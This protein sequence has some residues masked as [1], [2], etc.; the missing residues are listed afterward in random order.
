MIVPPVACIIQGLQ[1]VD[2]DKASVE[3]REAMKFLLNTAVPAVDPNVLRSRMWSKSGTHVGFFGKTNWSHEIATA[4]I[5]MSKFSDLDN[6]LYNAGL[7]DEEGNRIQ[8]SEGVPQKPKKKKRK[9]MQTKMGEKELQADYY[10]LCKFL[11]RLAK[12]DG[13]ELRMKRWDELC[14]GDRSGCPA[15][16]IDQRTNTVPSVFQQ[17][18]VPDD[19]GCNGDNLAH[20]FIIGTGLLS[21]WSSLPSLSESESEGA[22]SRTSS[23][24]GRPPVTQPDVLV[25]V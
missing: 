16:L 5:L 3:I 15:S 14:C 11:R 12:E 19:D 8:V 18:D 23:P 2:P 13:F 17:L 24:E 25:G 4:L 10:K 22:A 1:E 20:E 21:G 9:K 7:V 6:L